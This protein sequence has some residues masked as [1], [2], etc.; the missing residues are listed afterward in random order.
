MMH[1]DAPDVPGS[2]AADRRLF[3]LSAAKIRR[4]RRRGP[5]ARRPGVHHRRPVHRARLDRVDAGLSVRIGAFCSSTPPA[6]GSGSSWAAP[7]RSSGWR[8]TSARRRARPRLQQRQHLRQPA[9]AR[10]RGPLRAA[11]W[12]VHF[13]ELALKVSGAI[14]ARRWTPLPGGGFIYSFNGAHS[15]F[16]D[17]VRSLRSLAHRARARSP[18]DP[19]SR[20][21]RSACSNG[22]SS[23]RA[24][25]PSSAST[26]AA[27][28]ITTTSAAASCTSACST[29]P[30]AASAARARS[31]A[32]R[33][34]ARGRAGWRGRCSASPRSWNSS[35]RSPTT[36][37]QPFGGRAEIEALDARCRDRDLRLLHRARGGARRRA[38]L[39]HRR[40][41]PRARSAIGR[42]AAGR[43]VQR[44]RAGRQLRRGD[45]ARRACSGS[46][47]CSARAAPTALATRRPASRVLATLIDPA[48]RIS[49]GCRVIKA[50]CS[51]RSIIGRTGG[52]RCRPGSRDSARRIVPV[53]RLSPARGGAVRE[54]AQRR[55]DRT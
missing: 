47:I 29:R 44:S 41:R 33:R 16:V 35:R 50:C 24:R 6:N 27:I 49:P 19:T 43:S 40:A 37:W 52:T 9:A 31:R 5:P 1:I 34:S 2:A 17:T 23:T 7:G 13:Y 32:T 11:P 42:A 48:A 25:P 18:A 8:R 38:L 51:T 15:L 14:Q 26:T 30:T 45:C 36:R 22:C 39:G 46:A 21:R 55:T 3:A 28:A 20:T 54:A 10:A 53:G 12:E 4:S